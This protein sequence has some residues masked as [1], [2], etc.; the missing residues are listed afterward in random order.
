MLLKY[1][2]ANGSM[3]GAGLYG[4]PD[5]RKSV[6]YCRGSLGDF[7]F[8]CRFNISQATHAGPQTHHKNHVFEEFCVFKE[9]DVV[10]LWMLKLA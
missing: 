9:P 2:G 7:I 8:I 3:L 6:T 4:A 1:C 5:P 10:V